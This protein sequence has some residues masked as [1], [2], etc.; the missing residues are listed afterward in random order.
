MQF[1]IDIWI[2]LYFSI[3]S[4]YDSLPNPIAFCVCV[5]VCVCVCMCVCVCVWI[6]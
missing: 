5:C 3:A 6:I 1:S 4:Q 2:L